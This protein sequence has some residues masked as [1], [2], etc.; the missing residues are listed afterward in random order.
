MLHISD[1]LKYFDSSEFQEVFRRQQ[2]LKDPID[3]SIGIPEELTPAHIKAAGIRAIE[4]DHTTYTPANGLPELRATIAQKLADKNNI[5]VE[6]SQVTVVPGLTTGLLLLYLAILDP[7]DE[8]IVMDPAYPPYEALATAIGAEAM[9][10]LTLPTF[11]PDIPAIE[12]SITNRTRAII[13]NTPNNPTGTVYTKE[14]LLKVAEIAD[15]HGIW[16]I[17]DE[18]YEHFVYDGEHFSVG[19]MHPNVI[20]MNGFSKGYAM[21]GWRL[22]YIAGPQEV[23][24]AVNQLQQYVVFSSSSIAQHAAIAALDHPVEADYKKYQAKRDLVTRRLKE[25]GYAV[26]GAQG[27][28]YLFFQAPYGLTDL[29]FVEKAAERNVLLV[30]GRAFSSR[31]GYVRLSYGTSME[32]LQK[33]LDIIEELTKELGANHD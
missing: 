23:I 19:S 26:H 32:Q 21:T 3:L 7:G 27:A 14:D 18:I 17:S 4:S 8:I 31:H 9:S 15:K 11:H 5:H 20:T 24:D 2:Q 6:P 12:A 29:E 13:L 1:R 28:Y 10:V 25:M 30:P 33:G 16:L 22:G